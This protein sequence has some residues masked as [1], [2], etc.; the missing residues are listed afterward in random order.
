MI[1]PA[2]EPIDPDQAS[3]E[4]AA[5][6]ERVPAIALFGLLA[7]APAIG[8]RIAALGAAIMDETKGVS[9]ALREL[10]AI[11]VGRL[12]G[13]AYVENQHRRVA[14]S[15]HIAQPKIDAAAHGIEAD[16]LTAVERC[17]LR[18]A[19]CAAQGQPARQSDIDEE[20]RRSGARGT[21]AL[22]MTAGYFCMLSAVTSCVALDLERNDA[23]GS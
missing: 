23:S 20:M 21:T 12:C 15:M 17:V 16:S 14:A 1:R 19:Q 5:F 11:R 2:I 10:V 6:L 9:P 7:H 22:L 4:Q 18:I 8:G 13:S 3:P